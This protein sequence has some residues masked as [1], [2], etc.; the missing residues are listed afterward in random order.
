[1]NVFD[2]KN[3]TPSVFANDTNFKNDAKAGVIKTKKQLGY[4]QYGSSFVSD[5]PSP[6]IHA[7]IRE[8]EKK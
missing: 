3:N 1:M 6:N 4:K 7:D 8:K 2:W 5:K